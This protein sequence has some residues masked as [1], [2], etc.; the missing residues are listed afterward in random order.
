MNVSSALRR[1]SSVVPGLQP[2][3]C[4]RS[5]RACVLNSVGQSESQGSG[6]S[7]ASKI[8]RLDA[9]GRRAHHKCSVLGCPWRMNF[10]R[11]ACRDTS[12]IGK[13]TSASRLQALG[14][15]RPFG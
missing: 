14:I 6:H 12:A 2:A 11:A 3:I 7:R 8:A 1:S 4:G 15:M 13:S 5:F 10:S 9:S